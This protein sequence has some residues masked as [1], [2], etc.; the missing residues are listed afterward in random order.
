MKNGIPLSALAALFLAGCATPMRTV[1][2]AP[3]GSDANDGAKSRPF[4]TVPRALS[5]VRDLRNAGLPPG[6]VTVYLRGGTY[7]VREPIVFTPADSGTSNAPLTVASYPG[8]RA[9]LS[10]GERLAD[11]WTQTPGK[12]YWQLDVPRS[13]DWPF[14]K[15]E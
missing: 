8:E 12:P 7:A 2:V 15:S 14:T 11:T 4:A 3:D 6:P 13:R 1:F 10:G 9:V 5:A